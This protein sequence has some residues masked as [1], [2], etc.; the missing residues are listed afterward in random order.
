MLGFIAKPSSYCAGYRDGMFRIPDDMEGQQ[1]R[2]KLE[3]DTNH[4]K[5][6]A[7][8]KRDFISGLQNNTQFSRSSVIYEDDDML[9]VKA[10]LQFSL[11]IQINLG[12]SDRSTRNDRNYTIYIGFI[13]TRKSAYS[14]HGGVSKDYKD[15][16]E[17][18]VLRSV[19]LTDQPADRAKAAAGAAKSSSAKP[20]PAKP[21]PV[22]SA[23]AKPAPAKTETQKPAVSRL[24]MKIQDYPRERVAADAEGAEVFSKY[25]L[26]RDKLLAE[27]KQKLDDLVGRYNR[28]HHPSPDEVRQQI[29]WAD[30]KCG[31]ELCSALQRLNMSGKLFLKRGGSDDF[32]RAMVAFLKAE[33]EAA[34]LEVTVTTGIDEPWRFVCS[35][36]EHVQDL[37]AQW[38]QGIEAAKERRRQEHAEAVERMRTSVRILHEKAGELV[39]SIKPNREAADRAARD[40]ALSEQMLESRLER[41]R[42]SGRDRIRECET[43][44]TEAQNQ[45]N[46]LEKQKK[47]AQ[48]E[49]EGAFVLAIGKK[50]RL[51]E[52]IAALNAQIAETKC[53]VEA[54]ILQVDRA[55]DAAAADLEAVRN[56][57][58]QLRQRRD[59]M[60]RRCDELLREIELAEERVTRGEAALAAKLAE[61]V[62]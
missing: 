50:K 54:C 4:S 51:Q 7:E 17:D 45:L 60:D 52:Q 37:P 10:Y 33:I 9:V 25:V 31:N 19:R 16:W 12:V 27:R 48:Q 5:D 1:L 61:S 28:F 38:A 11:G 23:P 62:E 58:E 24:E 29:E 32:I 2:V 40:F 59:D 13:V 46:T 18:S 53:W 3:S 22:K 14:I 44:R 34:K 57:H 30:F 35:V 55:C 47:D 41:A 49:L 21:A 15:P 42:V 39:D 43:R 8:Q 20:A 26:E 6:F 56:E 36:P